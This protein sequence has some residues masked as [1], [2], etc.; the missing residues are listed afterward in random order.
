VDD[1]QA[2]AGLQTMGFVVTDSFDQ[3]DSSAQE[4]IVS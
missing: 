1:I 3:L 2:L 4:W